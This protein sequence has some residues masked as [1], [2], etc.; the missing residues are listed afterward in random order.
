MDK[1]IK[2][3]ASVDL[4]SRNSGSPATPFPSTT[5]GQTRPL[6]YVLVFISLLF[7]LSM[8]RFY[9]KKNNTRKLL[10]YMAVPLVVIAWGIGALG[11][12]SDPV[13]LS[14]YFTYSEEKLEPLRSSTSDREV[15]VEDVLEWEDRLFD[16]VN[17]EKIN[18]GAV[19]KI[20]PYLVVA[21]RDAAYLSFNAH[22]K[23]KG[24]IDPVSRDV[25]CIFIPDVCHDL[26][27]DTDAYSEMLAEIVMSR[28]NERMSAAE[29][30]TGLYSLKGDRFWIGKGEP[31]K[32]G[33]KTWLLETASQFRVPKPV[34]LAPGQ[35]QDQIQMVKDALSKVTPEQRAAVLRWSGGPGTKGATAHWLDLATKHMRDTNFDDVARALMIRS[36][37]QMTVW[38]AITA[39]NDSKYT[40]LA[41]RPFARVDEDDSIYTV[42]PTPSS[43]SH[44]ST[45]TTIAKAAATVM[46]HYFP[47]RTEEWMGIA[48]EI[49]H[50]RV[51]G[52][53]HFPVDVQQGHILGAQVALAN[54]RNS[55]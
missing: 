22:Q 26:P 12:G 29:A 16:L 38:D 42:M 25:S 47:E 10:L 51:W 7:R 33:L 45:S 13:S 44:P 15:T 55:G 50:S 24:S 9:M 35:D 14:T 32:L 20:L 3:T 4:G 11:C 49:G 53:V 31:K 8:V 28:V 37:V 19:S 41:L 5:Q 48:E 18:A 1:S 54:L 23:F 36:V 21:Q 34:E 46:S 17:D 30:E 27:V 52:G 43:P 6:S 40:H 39:G 2:T